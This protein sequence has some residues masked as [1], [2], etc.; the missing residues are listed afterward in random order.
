M[1][2]PARAGLRIDIWTRTEDDPEAGVEAGLVEGREG[3]VGGEVYRG[4]G[5]GLEDAP[6]GVERDGVETCG[7]EFL[8]DVGPEGGDG[9]AEG[10]KFAGAEEVGNEVR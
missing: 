6:V 8:E 5:R 1:R 2:D 10:V 7:C 9:E 3:A 4:G